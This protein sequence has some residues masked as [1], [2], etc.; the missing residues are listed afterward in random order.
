MP[1]YWMPRA[2]IGRR[3]FESGVGFTFC[4]VNWPASRLGGSPLGSV[5]LG[6][7]ASRFLASLF[8]MRDRLPQV[9]RHS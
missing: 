1:V 3:H 9:A 7:F 8:P 4:T 5:F 2:A 6:F